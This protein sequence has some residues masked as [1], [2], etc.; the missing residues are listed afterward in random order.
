M[1]TFAK[2]I[3]ALFHPLLMLTYGV[4]MA[5]YCTHLNVLPPELKLAVIGRIFLTSSV[6]PLL[7]IALLI[8]YGFV[9]DAE[10][11]DR[12][13]RYV[14]YLIFI[15]GYVAGAVFLQRMHMP[16]WIITGIAG[17]A[18]ALVI[19]LVIN[20]FWKISAHSIGIGGL[21]GGAIGGAVLLN[22]D[23]TPA[24]VF[25]I[26]AAGLVG[27]SRLYLGRHTPTQVYAGFFLGT[28]TVSGLLIS[29]YHLLHP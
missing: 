24:L 4:G 5:L 8:R 18:T 6:I 10:L 13:Q 28:L 29:L 9:G 15:F 21:L 11:T 19:A 20:L 23:P 14:P 16:F 27:T 22:I 17:S 12:S 26:P 7:L 1:R 3:S 25:L 2:L